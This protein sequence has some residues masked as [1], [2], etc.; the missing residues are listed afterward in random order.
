MFRLIEP[1]SGQIQTIVLVHTVSAYNVGYPIQYG[2]SHIVR[3]KHTY[4]T[5]T[6]TMMGLINI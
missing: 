5:Q 1:S 4:N 3:T 6:Q 2:I